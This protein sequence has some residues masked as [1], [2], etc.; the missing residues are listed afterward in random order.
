MSVFKIRERLAVAGTVT[1]GGDA[2]I[3]R[4]AADRLDLGAGDSLNIPSGN[5]SIAGGT[6]NAASGTTLIANG[7]AT[8]GTALT[9]N[10]VIKIGTQGGTPAFGFQHNGTA[11]YILGVAVS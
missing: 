3:S 2:V 9:A 7:T 11:Y 5:M 8:L 4:G 6:L 1:L 10:G